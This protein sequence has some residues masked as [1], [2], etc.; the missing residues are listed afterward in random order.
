MSQLEALNLSNLKAVDDDGL[1][2][3]SAAA[4][5]TTLTL[6]RCSSLR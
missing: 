1:R 5:L 4:N 6:D 3:L 2:A